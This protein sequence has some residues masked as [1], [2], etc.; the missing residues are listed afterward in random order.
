MFGTLWLLAPE[1]DPQYASGDHRLNAP[2]TLELR[3]D[4]DARN[5][6]ILD[7]IYE[8]SHVDVEAAETILTQSDR[9]STRVR[10]LHSPHGFTVEE[11]YVCRDFSDSE[12]LRQM[13]GDQWECFRVNYVPDKDKQPDFSFLFAVDPV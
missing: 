5:R 8:V 1:D 9:G 12:I 3:S 10:T 13:Y 11:S 4:C 2:L 7:K 6:A